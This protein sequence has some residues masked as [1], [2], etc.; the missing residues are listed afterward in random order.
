MMAHPNFASNFAKSENNIFEDVSIE[1]L[2]LLQGQFYPNSDFISSDFQSIEGGVLHQFEEVLDK[3][4]TDSDLHKILSE[5][6]MKC[7][8]HKENYDNLKAQYIK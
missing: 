6:R 7:A 1:P 4:K 5:E 2:R 8:L 3:L